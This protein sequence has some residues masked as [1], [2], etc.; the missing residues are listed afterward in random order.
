MEYP[1]L[2][3]VTKRLQLWGNLIQRG[4]N[5][6]CAETTLRNIK[7]LELE[8]TYCISPPNTSID[9]HGKCQTRKS[10]DLHKVI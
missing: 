8:G 5:S 10:S 3:T 2:Y 9:K 1:S 4:S 7:T 6:Q